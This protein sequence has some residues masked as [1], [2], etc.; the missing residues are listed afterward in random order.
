M[1]GP[2]AAAR[3]FCVVIVPLSKRSKRRERMTLLELSPQYRTQALR[4]HGRIHSLKILRRQC[5]SPVERALLQTRIHALSEL[6][7]EARDLAVLT[8]R[9]YE[10]GY[11]RNG[12]YTL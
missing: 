3:F 4:L 5:S 8:E 1:I 11:K 7:R 6:Y 9:Y 2:Q 12:K 10:R